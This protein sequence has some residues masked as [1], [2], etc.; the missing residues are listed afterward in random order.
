[1]TSAVEYSSL[2]VELLDP[3]HGAEKRRKPEYKHDKELCSSSKV[4]QLFET[5]HRR[6]TFNYDSSTKSKYFEGSFIGLYPFSVQSAHSM[7]ETAHR[8]RGKRARFV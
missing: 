3:G 6:S 4:K 8:T 5:T 2:S 1:M 7:A